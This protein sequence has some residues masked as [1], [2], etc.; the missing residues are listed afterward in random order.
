M[1]PMNCYLVIFPRDKFYICYCI[2]L[3]TSVTK[4]FSFTDFT[5][6]SAID[7]HYLGIGLPGQGLYLFFHDQ[8]WQVNIKWT[9]LYTFSNLVSTKS[10]Q[11]NLLLNEKNIASNRECSK[12]SL[13]L[14]TLSKVIFVTKSVLYT[15][16][17][18]E[19]YFQQE[20]T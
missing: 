19:Y 16:S 8:K 1:L 6:F 18:L 5:Q 14:E 3:Y 20:K 10:F 7:I 15:S 11:D 17:V 4:L 13:S 2:L 9:H 12:Y